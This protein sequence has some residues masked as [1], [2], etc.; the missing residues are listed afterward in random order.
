MTHPGTAGKA[1]RSGSGCGTA[2]GIGL[3]LAGGLFLGAN[4]LGTRLALLLL[5]LLPMAAI[6]WPLL[7]VAWGIFK[8]VSRLTTGRARIGVLEFLFL[9]SVVVCG[10]GLTLAYR[11]IES[12]GLQSRLV[13]ISRLVEQHAGQFPQ[14]VFI[15][16]Q[17]VSLP[18]SLPTSLP[19]AGPVNVVVSLPAGNIVVEA[20]P[21][22]G[23]RS[24]S[25]NSPGGQPDPVPAD[26]AD[27]GSVR[28]F[29]RVWAAD[30]EQAATRAE[31]VRLIAGPLDSE[32]GEFP[33]RVE[34]FGG[35]EMALELLVTLP[36]GV[37][38][39]AISEEGSVRV[40]G[41]FP[42]VEART[43]NGPIAVSG[44]SGTVSLTARNGAVRAVGIG[45][46]LH[47]RGRR[48]AIEVESVAGPATVESEGAPVW[49]SGAGSSVKVHGRNAPVDISD[50]MGPVEIETQISPIT[51]EGIR[52]AASVRSDYGPI[53]AKSVD[54]L[55]RIRT[56]SANVEVLE[57]RAGA[58]IH[59]DG[60]SIVLADVRGPITVTSGRGEV[61]A[62]DLLGRASFSGHAGSIIV[63]GFGDS[64]SVDAD[65]A[66]VDVV[67]EALRGDVMLKTGRGNVRLTLPPTGSFT[68]S[69]ETDGGDVESDFALEQTTA[70]GRS[71]WSGRA[72]SGAERVMISTDSGDVTVRSGPDR[73]SA[74]IP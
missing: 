35:T 31:A 32:T 44:A 16:E 48:A 69:A 39:S 27:A 29:K 71:R 10:T 4:L 52:G 56:E 63:R 9:L 62:S 72:G 3:I 41:P 34:D 57:A 58:E 6:W 53:L 60:G 11:V 18:T 17:T 2:L 19:S 30:E 22:A 12:Q 50:S 67:T 24:E 7:L 49:I 43:S 36:R 66:L 54:G 55:L 70:D 25:P 38:V 65:D 59:G 40:E 15:T 37:G 26:R 33:I 28:L 14:R 51:L 8:V 45:G 46:A 47:I 5:D 21:S 64:L 1:P 23:E 68:L 73:S 74:R 42:R 13:E 20:T 61:R